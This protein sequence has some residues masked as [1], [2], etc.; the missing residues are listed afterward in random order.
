MVRFSTY[1]NFN[2]TIKNKSIN[3]NEDLSSHNLNVS[4]SIFIF[5][6]GL[7]G[8]LFGSKLLVT[9]SIDIAK[10]YGIRETVIGIVILA[11]GTSLPEVVTSIVASI[12]KEYN[13]A[14]GNIVG[15]S[16][17][18]ILAIGGSVLLIADK[19]DIEI[20]SISVFDLI[21]FL[22]ATIILLL[23]Y[24][25]KFTITKLYGFLLVMF[26]IIWISLIFLY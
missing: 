11:L 23:F 1:F 3:E 15:S 24:K 18:N 17:F 13:I 6:L 14:I 22:L 10:Y 19:S 16:I 7:V 5:I 9:G 26:Y 20:T 2:N 4:K 25:F 8:I 12:K 21:P